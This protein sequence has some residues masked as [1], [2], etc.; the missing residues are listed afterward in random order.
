MNKLKQPTHFIDPSKDNEYYRH[1]IKKYIEWVRHCEG[2]DFIDGYGEVWEDPANV[3]I[4]ES[5]WNDLQDLSD[6]VH[7]EIINTKQ[8]YGRFTQKII[9]HEKIDILHFT[10]CIF[11]SLDI[12]SHWSFQWR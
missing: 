8:L 1:L 12:C 6:E 5:E 7:R 10:D 4:T 3:G 9:N 11:N 2:V